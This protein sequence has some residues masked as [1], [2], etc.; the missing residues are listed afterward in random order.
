MSQLRHISS[1]LRAALAVVAIWMLMFSAV[2]SGSAAA[3]AGDPVY[4]DNASASVG[5]FACFKRHMT[6]RADAPNEKAPPGHANKGHHCPDCCLV[7]QAVAAVLPER[8]ATVARPLTAPP[9]PICY[10]AESSR[11]PESAHARAVNGARAPP[12]LA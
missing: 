5:L 2:T 9:S 1:N 4:R 3:Y 6:Q 10:L 8:V 11:S 12:A 7:A